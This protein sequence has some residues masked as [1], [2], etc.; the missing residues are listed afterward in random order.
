MMSILALTL[1]VL[2]PLGP[3]GPSPGE[4]P[5]QPE[6]VGQSSRGWVFSSLPH[7][8]LWFHGM[9]SVDPFGPG[10]QPLYDPSYPARIRAVKEE[11]GFFPTP[12]DEHSGRFRD[13]FRA[14]PAFEV[15]HFLPLYFADASRIEFFSA[16]E[17]LAVASERIP[18]ATSPNTSM[19]LMATGAVLPTRGQREVLGEFV[20]VLQAEDAFFGRFRRGA[21]AHREASH[22]AL[23]IFW[24]GEFGPKLGALLKGL[25]LSGGTVV[26]SDA[27][28]LEGRVFA[29]DP[30]ND[31]DNVLVVSSPKAGEDD[32]TV[33]FSMIRELSFPLARRVLASP[34]AGGGQGPVAE[35]LVVRAAVRSGAMV[36]EM[37]F[38][39]FLPGYQKFFLSR[40]GHP[41]PAE[42][43]LDNA[44]QRAFPLGASVATALRAEIIEL[45]K[46][47]TE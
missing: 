37:F 1:A 23:Q 20:A 47:D 29:G 8:D 42:G 35:E 45:N 3:E 41:V 4:N 14:D 33:I 10:P 26:L 44:F 34:E 17:A 16:L 32:E 2:A 27:L 11:A 6:P 46:V 5:A 13:A 38:P 18:R 28:G 19:G 25:G 31:R 40:D 30:R 43:E 9:A 22:R 39:G 24:D 36:M 21:A 12:L 15:F 7:V